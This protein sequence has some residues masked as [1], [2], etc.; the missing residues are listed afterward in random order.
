MSTYNTNAY[1]HCLYDIVSTARAIIP[2]ERD[3][4]LEHAPPSPPSPDGHWG[5]QAPQAPMET[6]C[7][8][9]RPSKSSK[10]CWSAAPRAGPLI[11]LSKPSIFFW[12]SLQ[13]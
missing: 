6:P 1:S 9:A 2:D 12:N 11:L 3:Y 8:R 13:R 10:L 5:P 4:P 7:V